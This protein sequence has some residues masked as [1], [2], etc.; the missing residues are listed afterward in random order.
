MV[1]EERPDIERR[2]AMWD[3][4]SEACE[5]MTGT[6]PAPPDVCIDELTGPELRRPGAQSTTV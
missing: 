6:R 4:C 2:I 3:A 1:D 5:R